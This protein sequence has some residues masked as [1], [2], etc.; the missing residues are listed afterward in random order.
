[1]DLLAKRLLLTLVPAAL[2]LGL[3]HATIMG[4]NGLVRRH[5]MQQDLERAHRKLTAIEAE[6]ILLDREVSQLRS[7]ED[8]LRRAVAEELL[9]VPPGSVVYRFDE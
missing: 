3:V 8:T 5:H 4:N 7:D 9:L 1:M 2:V 6:N